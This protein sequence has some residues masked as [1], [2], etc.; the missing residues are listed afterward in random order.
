[1]WF[2]NIKTGVSWQIDDESH[3][4][5]LKADKNYEVVADPT[6]PKTTTRKKSA[7]TKKE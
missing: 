1:M 7:P 5:R 6:K 3:I 2:K 4:K